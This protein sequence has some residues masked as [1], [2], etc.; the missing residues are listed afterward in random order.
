MVMKLS[1]VRMLSKKELENKYDEQTASA[2]ESLSFYRDEII[3]REQNKL[4]KAMI[5]LTGFIIILTIVQ[6]FATVKTLL[7]I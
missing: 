6:L 2:C 7:T 1:E 4:T 3:R 5:V